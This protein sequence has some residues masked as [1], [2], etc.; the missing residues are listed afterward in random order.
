M[1]PINVIPDIQSQANIPPPPRLG[2]SKFLNG[3]SDR[4]TSGSAGGGSEPDLVTGKFDTN[5]SYSPGS[6]TTTN[7]EAASTTSLPKATGSTTMPKS[8]VTPKTS[9][10]VD[11]YNNG[12]EVSDSEKPAT[13]KSTGILEFA[14]RKNPKSDNEHPIGPTD[15]QPAM[16]TPGEFVLQK[17]AVDIIKQVKGIAALKRLNKGDVYGF[18]KGGLL[19][20]STDPKYKTPKLG[21]IPEMQEASQRVRYPE[22][23][24][25]GVE[26]PAHGFKGDP[27][28]EFVEPKT[29]VSKASVKLNTVEPRMPLKDFIN[30]NTGVA[31]DKSASKGNIGVTRD[32]VTQVETRAYEPPTTVQQHL[33]DK[34]GVSGR[35]KASVPVSAA[36]AAKQLPTID[37]NKAVNRNPVTQVE[38]QSYKPA[39]PVQ[40]MINSSTGVSGRNKA[41]VPVS[42]AEAA[43]QGGA[44][45]QTEIARENFLKKFAPKSG[46]T[47][48]EPY[49]FTNV[50]SL[51]PPASEQPFKTGSANDTFT[52]SPEKFVGPK[53]PRA[54]V[55]KVGTVETIGKMLKAAPESG[56]NALKGGIKIGSKAFGPATFLHDAYNLNK[57]L[58]NLDDPKDKAQAKA[59]FA[60]RWG[61]SALGAAVGAGAGAVA[62]SA[63]GPHVA[64]IGSLVGGS[65]GYFAPDV[66]THLTG[67]KT[68]EDKAREN[69]ATEEAKHQ[70][71]VEAE[72]RAAEQPGLVD[73][74]KAM[75]DSISKTSNQPG[76]ISPKEFNERTEALTAAMQ[77]QT[78]SGIAR[79]D[80]ANTPEGQAAYDKQVSEWSERK[81]QD[82]ADQRY[83][84]HL[85]TP[86]GRAEADKESARQGIFAAE[87]QA[88]KVLAA[89]YQFADSTVAAATK[90]VEM[91]EKLLESENSK[92][93]TDR[94]QQIADENHRMAV[95]QHESQMKHY[96][97]VNNSA[98]KQYENKLNELRIRALD[99]D[100]DAIKQLNNISTSKSS[101][102]GTIGLEKAQKLGL[103]D[104]SEISKVADLTTD[105]LD[106]L[107]QQAKKIRKD[108]READTQKFLASVAASD[109]FGP[110]GLEGSTVL[111]L[112]TGKQD[113]LGNLTQNGA[114]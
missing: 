113:D 80:F 114:E 41:S 99:G 72:E 31:R 12:G 4:A 24:Q 19:E 87:K 73:E 40:E 38:T 42:A 91:A 100:A 109:R 64:A 83:R 5:S 47:S 68:A 36:E 39:T 45:K 105:D 81:Q 30:V 25:P 50:K 111:S 52:R 66:L 85:R 89:P 46:T 28:Q 44:T 63:A 9:F 96:D 67:G 43:K 55:P 20:K 6:K 54:E 61:S 35:N 34:T 2:V 1:K 53:T 104:V 75:M 23:Y 90:Q 7:F 69:V 77:R 51:N 33:N 84:E 93:N 60:A 76:H 103:K 78:G 21:D 71:F 79:Q 88:R 101:G 108:F 62:G 112:I 18:A 10:R 26:T 59:E 17:P 13:R 49:D 102:T 106:S 65:L 27:A 58:N 82:I 92:A 16:L 95:E 37:T 11:G 110:L 70:Q 15:T 29:Q 8:S 57:V 56:L 94:R 48:V 14:K 98:Q 86:E 97:D 32:P 74:N 3:V 107:R 22:A